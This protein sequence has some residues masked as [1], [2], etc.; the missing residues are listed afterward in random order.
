MK[1]DHPFAKRDHLAAVFAL[2]GTFFRSEP[3]SVSNNTLIFQW[4]SGGT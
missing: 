2:F 3:T 1:M 4:V